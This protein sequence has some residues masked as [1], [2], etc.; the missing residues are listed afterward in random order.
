MFLRGGL[1]DVLK[2][3][4]ESLGINIVLCH[5]SRIIVVGSSLELLT[6]LAL[7]MA[8]KMGFTL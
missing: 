5:F 8:N 4:L 1:N 7:I 2:C 3:E 6:C